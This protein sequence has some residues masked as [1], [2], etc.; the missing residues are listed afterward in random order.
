MLG[1]QK[2]LIDSYLPADR[3]ESAHLAQSLAVSSTCQLL[4]IATLLS[5]VAKPLVIITPVHCQGAAGTLR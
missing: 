2:L 1:N 4:L 3:G 5:S